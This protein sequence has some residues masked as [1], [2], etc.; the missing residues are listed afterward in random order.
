MFKQRMDGGLLYLFIQSFVVLKQGLECFE[1][2]HLAG[3]ACWGLRLSLHHGH[4]ERPLVPGDK[5]L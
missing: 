5:A 4:P 3:H 2:F 1:D